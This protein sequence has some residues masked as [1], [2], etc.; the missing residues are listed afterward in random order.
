MP[1]D[2]EDE[3]GWNALPTVSDDDEDALESSIGPLRS[4]LG[5][6]K[7]EIQESGQV[8]TISSQP[9]KV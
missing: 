9:E 6:Y 7:Y 8:L 5:S 2:P 1:F 3:E 4:A